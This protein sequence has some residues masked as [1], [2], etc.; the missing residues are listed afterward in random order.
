MTTPTFNKPAAASG[1]FTPREH[2]GHLILITTVHERRKK[3]D[4]LKGEIVDEVICDLVDLDGDGALQ[5]AV[6]LSHPG[7]TNR[8][9]GL[10]ANILGRIGTVPSTK[11]NPA[12]V[13]DDF[14]EAAGDVA[15]ATAWVTAYN[16]GQISQPAAAPAQAQAAPAPAAQPVQQQL[17]AAAP[18]AATAN[19]SDL[20]KQ[21][22]AAGLD[23]TAISQA[24]GLDGNVIAA[25]RNLT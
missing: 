20:A 24:T 17:P 16:A 15:K 19:P 2:L 23:D 21:L 1:Y 13:L 18:A 8:T 11:G 6:I 22:I 7:L 9:R 25:I 3:H 12:F 14:D 5:E 4:E 10:E